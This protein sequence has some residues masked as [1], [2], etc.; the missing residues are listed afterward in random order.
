MRFSIIFAIVLS[1]FSII[2]VAQNSESYE[3]FFLAWS[4][5]WPIAFSLLMTLLIGFLIGILFLIPTIYRSTQ[6]A[7]NLGKE[8]VLMKKSLENNPQKADL[9]GVNNDSVK[10]N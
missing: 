8:N 2:F 7:N 5:N 3:I 6:K 4:F 1:A 10:Y 9:D